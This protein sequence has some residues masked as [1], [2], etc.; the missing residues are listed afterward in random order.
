MGAGARSGRSTAAG[1]RSKVHTTED[2]PSSRARR[3]AVARILAWARWTPS[4]VPR[5]TTDGRRSGGKD[6]RPWRI[7]MEEPFGPHR[8]AVRDADPEQGVVGSVHSH[9]AGGVGADFRGLAVREGPGRRGVE[10]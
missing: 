2:T 6:G 1:F 3:T 10:A 9:G 8:A 5:A 7:R 4:N